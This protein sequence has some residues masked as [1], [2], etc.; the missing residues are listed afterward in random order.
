MVTTDSSGHYTVP[1]LLPGLYTMTAEANGF[2]KFNSIHNKLEPNS[3]VALD[4]NLTVGATTETIE[5]SSSAEVLQTES[6]SVQNEVTGNANS[7]P[8][9]E[10]SQSDLLSAIPA[11]DS[12]QLHAGR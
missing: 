11:R 10:R 7:K 4:G 2:K 9:I 12:Q 6:G 5:V 3:T 1:N 8:G